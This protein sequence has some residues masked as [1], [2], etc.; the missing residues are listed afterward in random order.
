[1]RPLW[2]G[3]ITFGLIYIPVKLYSA[4]QAIEID[5]DLLSKK[6]KS[7]IRYARI[8]TKTG[9]E[10]AWRDVVKGYEYK[11]GDYV[12]LEPSDF[13]KVDLE[14]S[15]NIEISSFVDLDQVDP[16]YFDQPYYLEPDG[17]S[18]KIYAL[19]REALKQTNKAGV[20]E[21]VMRNREHLCLIKAES[22]LLILNRLRYQAELKPT[23]NLDIP[24]KTNLNPNEL[25]MAKE[26]IEKMS[27]SF[28]ITD[29]QDD[30][31]KKLQQLIAA[32]AKRKTFKVVEPEFKPTE[33]TDLA[34]Q[35]RQSLIKFRE[36]ADNGS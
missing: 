9:E 17:S 30:Y 29:Y 8:D 28:D 23:N 1:M 24:K 15:K 20:A 34:E 32:K 2:T 31:L 13:E 21:F 25:T 14:K 22:N 26:L 5:L 4:T 19:L 27:E 18:Q 11:K 35:L 7:P 33:T 12:I 6:E 16:I 3:G 10:I 36:Q